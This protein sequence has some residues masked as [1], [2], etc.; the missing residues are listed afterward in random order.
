MPKTAALR[1]TVFRYPG[2]IGGGSAPPPPVRVLKR[3][4]V[5][6]LFMYARSQGLNSY[7]NVFVHK[8]ELSKA[9]TVITGEPF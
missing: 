8:Y 4:V 9:H 7:R 3:N 5:A 6:Q 1:A 2:K